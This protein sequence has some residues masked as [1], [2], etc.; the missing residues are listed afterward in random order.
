[1]IYGPNSAAVQAII[2]RIPTLT[3]DECNRLVA[4]WYATWGAVRDAAWDA[5]WSATWGAVR[6]AAWDAAWYATWY[7]TWGAAW[8][9]AW[10][11]TW[12]AVRD[13]AWDA[14][15]YA[16]WGAVRATLTYD[17]ATIDG[18]YTI[19]QRDLLLAPWIE[20]CGMPEGLIATAALDGEG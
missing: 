2:D 10:Y 14:A 5:A 12:G 13:A 1:M 4:A 9:A 18:H 7:A 17:L 16:T 20:V 8:D 6:D 15:W 3:E 19:A 11:A